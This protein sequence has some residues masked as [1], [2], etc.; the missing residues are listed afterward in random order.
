MFR[1]TRFASNQGSSRYEGIWYFDPN[2]SANFDC[3]LDDSIVD[4]R[5]AKLS[6]QIAQPRF[7]SG[8]QSRKYS[9]LNIGALDVGCLLPVATYFAQCA[10][11]GWIGLSSRRCVIFAQGAKCQAAKPHS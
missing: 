1:V 6:Q 2:G 4:W 7:I 11:D 9:E 10:A 5:F 3:S 8:I